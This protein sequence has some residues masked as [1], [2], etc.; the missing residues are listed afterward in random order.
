MSFPKRG[1]GRRK[2]RRTESLD[3]LTQYLCHIS[4]IPLLTHDEERELAMR[5][6]SGDGKARDKFIAANLRLVFKFVR[7]YWHSS[8]SRFMEDLVAEGNRGLIRA[9]DLFDPLRGHAFSTYAFFWIRQAINESLRQGNRTI[10]FPSHIEQARTTISAFRDAFLTEHGRE[11]AAEEVIAACDISPPLVRQ[12]LELRTD[13]V[14]SLDYPI[15]E[16]GE[17]QFD[18]SERVAA[19]TAHEEMRATDR[20]QLAEMTAVLQRMIARA[21]TQLERRNLGI[22]RLRFGLDGT[23]RIRK[24]EEVKKATGLSRQRIDQLVRRHLPVLIKKWQFEYGKGLE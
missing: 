9:V 20:Q 7:K 17:H 15:K 18:F 10:R 2:E 5:V 12:V 19:D 8:G 22:V 1:A 14:D 13:R 3:S 11:P 23:Y 21:R 4:R 24:L 6:R 16:D